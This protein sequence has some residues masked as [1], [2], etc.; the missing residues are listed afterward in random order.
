M[1]QTSWMLDHLAHE[2]RVH[3]AAA[4][5]DRLAAMERPTEQSYRAFLSRVYCFEAPLEAAFA[6]TTGFNAGLVQTHTRTKRLAAD[7]EAIGVA[8]GGLDMGPTLGFGDVADALGWMYVLQRNTLLHGLI[9]RQLQS[10]I[11][12]VVEK[13]NSY[14]TAHENTAGAR[15]R[16]LGIALDTTARR[17]YIA[18]RIVHAA[19]EA[20]RCQ[21]QWYACEAFQPRRSRPATQGQLRGRAA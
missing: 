4:D 3:H 21:R 13:A 18:A 15:L 19:G 16:E 5:G 14:L 2:T 8:A 20:F 1:Q 6:A 12:S 11:G 9:F 10:R 7:L 17:T